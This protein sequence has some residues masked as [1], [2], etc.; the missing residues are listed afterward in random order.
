MAHEV[1]RDALNRIE[2]LHLTWARGLRSRKEDRVLD[3]LMWRHYES[4]DRVEDNAE[5]GRKLTRR[6]FQR[7]D[8][9]VWSL[10]ACPVC[11]DDERLCPDHQFV[12]Y[13]ELTGVTGY[14][15]HVVAMGRYEEPNLPVV[16]VPLSS[17]RYRRHR[18]PSE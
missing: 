13:D 17:R 8:A 12:L 18:L 7:R 14:V 3:D 9:P 16:G 6:V 15:S 1:E 4:K 10:Y 5:A 2:A 11:V